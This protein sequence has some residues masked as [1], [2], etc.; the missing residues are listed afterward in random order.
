MAIRFFT[1]LLCRISAAGLLLATANF[2]GAQQAHKK[3][4]PTDQ[5]LAVKVQN[6]LNA[7]HVFNGMSVVPSVSHG[8]VTLSGQVTSDAARILASNEAG[9]V[10]GIKTV[11]NNLTVQTVQ[12]VQTPAVATALPQPAPPTTRAPTPR[13]TRSVVLP[14]ST[15]LSV[16]TSD[17]LTSKTAKVNDEF[18]GTVAADVIQD[19]FTVIPMGT[20]VLGRVVEAKEAAHFAGSA[21]LT[22]EL[23]SLQLNTLNGSQNLAVV[24]DPVSNKAKG[25]GANTAEKTAGG[26]GIGA[27]IGGLAGG[28]LGAGIGALAGGG[29]GAGA[30]GVT[31]G[32]DIV[33]PAETLLRFSLSSSVSIPVTVRNGKQVV[34]PP[35]SGPALHVRPQENAPDA[36]APT[37]D[38]GTPQQ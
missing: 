27:L 38:S 28:G 3:V 23:V 37:V 9:S 22:V 25:R 15:V 2:A 17:A 26:A 13:E 24:T 20:A 19:G 7:D 5:V 35:P 14:G 18:H 29:L 6:A 1:P 11:L 30:N 8:V 33:V 12:T 34:L 4:P 21:A 32:Q 16:R 31:R 36:D 10:T